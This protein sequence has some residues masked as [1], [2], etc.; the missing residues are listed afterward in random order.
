[1]TTTESDA[2]ERDSARSDVTS[3]ETKFA[4]ANATQSNSR[5]KIS[6]QPLSNAAA[7]AASKGTD[8][9]ADTCADTCTEEDSTADMGPGRASDDECTAEAQF[10]MPWLDFNAR[11]QLKNTST[12]KRSQKSNNDNENINNSRKNGKGKSSNGFKFPNFNGHP[13]ASKSSGPSGDPKEVG[14]KA[15]TTDESAEADPY[16]PVTG[17]WVDLSV[18]AKKTLWSGWDGISIMLA[19]VCL[20]ALVIGMSIISIPK[21][22]TLVL[23]NHPIETIV[24]LLLIVGIPLANFLVWSALRKNKYRHSVIRGV[25]LGSAIGTSLITIAICIAAVFAGH[26]L[27]SEIGSGFSA[28]FVC[29]A[30]VF[31]LT[32]I[33]SVYLAHRSRLTHDFER[34]RVRILLATIAG[35]MMA[36]LTLA[37]AEAR[38]WYIRLAEVKTLSSVPAERKDG[39]NALRAINPE[40]EILMECSDARAVGL[41]GLFLPIKSSTQHQLYFSLTGKPYS[42]KDITNN[43]LSSMPDDY[44]SRHVVGEKIAGLSVTRSS[45]TGNI[46]P[47][48]LSS[49]LDWTFVFKNQGQTPQEARAEIG[50]PPGAVITGMTLWNK[51]EPEE[52]AFSADGKAQK[53]VSSTNTGSQ[54]QP[55]S[56]TDLGHGRML[57]HCFPVKDAEELKLKV[58]MVVPLKP[59]GQNSCTLAMPRLIAENFKLENEHQVRMRSNLALSSTFKGLQSSNNTDGTQAI[60]GNLPA[61]Q[62][63]NSNLQISAKRN[64]FDKQVIAEDKVATAF[65]KERAYALALQE[66]KR[67][68]KRLIHK[69]EQQALNINIDESGDVQRQLEDL[70]KVLERRSSD[71]RISPAQEEQLKTIPPHYVLEKQTEISAPAPKNLVIVVDGSATVKSERDALVAALGQIPA[72][73]PTRILLASN[74]DGNPVAMNLKEGLSKIRTEQFLGGHDNLKFVVKASELAGEVQHGAML[75]IHGPQPVM[76]QEIYIMEPYVGTPAFYELPLGAGDT[77]TYDFFK[78]HTE[79]GPFSQIPQTSGT[80]KGDLSAFFSKW[81]SNIRGYETSLCSTCATENTRKATEEEATELIALHA[82]QVV[83]ALIL[84]RHIRK[85]ART[86]VAY[87]L[88]TPVSS[89]IVPEA[90]NNNRDIDDAA[91]AISKAEDAA[92]TSQEAAILSAKSLPG[93]MPG[94]PSLTGA[95]NGT[96]TSQG[97]DAT[98]V[99]GVN[100]AGNVRVNNLANLE[101]MLNIFTSISEILLLALGSA[102]LLNSLI[103][104]VVIWDLL[105]HEI[106]LGRGRRAGL[107][108]ALIT[109]GMV[110]PGTINWFIASA[111][112]ANLFS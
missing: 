43:D 18:P 39:W 90:S 14:H 4:K 3:G 62:I 35:G 93:G 34:S 86:A 83:K 81:K 28:G 111:R 12:R 75:W 58:S 15:D 49:T 26:Q 68:N 65:E 74:D 11:L 1:M 71:P 60:F 87:G 46:H 5:S 108:S 50:L 61:D 56:A 103:T 99:T 59:E 52:A 27:E 7:K 110:L 102:I 25:T 106:E 78:N 20:P 105:G 40:K 91:I 23:L 107:G 82:N 19:G 42:F 24:E 77:D 112:D 96:I 31:T 85:A 21:R 80:V 2:A 9:C 98:L 8:T 54:N 76:N 6:D 104:E 37:A 95:T 44:L 73:I 51:G 29:I 64:P 69:L 22:L 13:R 70:T 101:A 30:L 67:H 41:C 38:P 72:N 53:Y 48:T 88:V 36:L 109:L 10:A 79:I 33:T 63:E 16:D 47:D 45:I 97:S 89:A 32:G 84:E 92:Q 57:V 55:A 66:A 17:D 100:T 94:E